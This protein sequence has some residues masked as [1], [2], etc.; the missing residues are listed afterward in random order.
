MISWFKSLFKTKPSETEQFESSGLQEGLHA[1]HEGDRLKLSKHF[2]EALAFYDK[3]IERQIGE[4]HNGRA[5]CLQA[6]SYHIDALSDFDKAI[7]F[8]PGDCN[9]YFMRA[10]SRIRLGDNDGAISDM[11]KAIELS[12]V[13]N[14]LNR[15]YNEYSTKNGENSIHDLYVADLPAI[16]A[17][18]KRIL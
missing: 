10:W 11:H 3:A 15:I 9:I 4:G 16:E 17:I 7:H 2:D 13:K 8:S 12:K 6:L 1:L 5:V 14:E 18:A